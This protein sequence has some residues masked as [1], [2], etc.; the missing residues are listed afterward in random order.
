MKN[1]A[2][3]L[4]LLITLC[5]SFLSSAQEVK[6][7]KS[8]YVSINGFPLEE[9]ARIDGVYKIA[10]DG[11]VDMPL[12]GKVSVSDMKFVD[13]AAKIATA[14]RKTQIS[15]TAHIHMC[16]AEKGEFTVT[17]VT[18]AGFVHKPGPKN[19]A[20]GMTLLN[21]IDAAGGANKYGNLNNIVLMR[22]K[23]AEIY[24]FR[25]SN[26]KNILLESGDYIEVAMPS[27][28]SR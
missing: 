27:M 2:A 21:A 20:P 16:A 1:L 5:G 11:T 18:V 28:F 8:I 14:Y 4:F 7:G 19:F 9:K 22:G 3:L 23:S 15:F 12:I 13:A 26:H 24:D 17:P 25:N 6:A 10:D